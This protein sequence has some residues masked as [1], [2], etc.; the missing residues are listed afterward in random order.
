MI[1]GNAC[2]K[3]NFTILNTLPVND[4]SLEAG[5]VQYTVFLGL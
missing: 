4:N 5:E 1:R 2:S 3:A